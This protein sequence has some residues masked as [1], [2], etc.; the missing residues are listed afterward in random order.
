METDILYCSNK[1]CALVGERNHC[2]LPLCEIHPQKSLH[3]T[4]RK[5]MNVSGLHDLVVIVK[6]PKYV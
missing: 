5:Y 2:H 6:I 4:L 1:V 3:S